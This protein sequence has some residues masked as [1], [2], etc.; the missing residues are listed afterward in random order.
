MRVEKPLPDTADWTSEG[1]TGVMVVPSGEPSTAW[2]E[3]MAAARL[4]RPV[5]ANRVLVSC[6]VDVGFV[7]DISNK[8]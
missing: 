8:V 2:G 6:M 1:E 5:T 7:D 4:R 3:G